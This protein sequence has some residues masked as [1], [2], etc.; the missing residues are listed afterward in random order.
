MDVIASWAMLKQMP[1]SV[2]VPFQALVDDGLLDVERLT[3]SVCYAYADE[4]GILMETAR[5]LETARK[6]HKN[7]VR[8]HLYKLVRL[9]YIIP[10]NRATRL[11]RMPQRTI[12]KGYA[13]TLR[14]NGKKYDAANPAQRIGSK[15][16]DKT[17][18]WE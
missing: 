11:E 12:A 18:R 4:D 9:N 14:P 10:I 1:T 13:L 15:T 5:T 16:W 3:L 7:T 6:L 17:S 8:R 2:N